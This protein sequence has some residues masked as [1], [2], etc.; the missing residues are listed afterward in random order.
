L[1]YVVAALPGLKG[2]RLPGLTKPPDTPLDEYD[3]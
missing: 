1:T 2:M 3:Q